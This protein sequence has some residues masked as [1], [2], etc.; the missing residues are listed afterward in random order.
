VFVFLNTFAMSAFGFLY[1]FIKCWELSLVL[2]G[3]LPFILLAG[4]LAIKSFTLSAQRS[5]VSY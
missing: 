5:K 1:A 3:A 4:V 2:T